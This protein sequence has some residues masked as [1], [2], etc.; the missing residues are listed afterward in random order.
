MNIRTFPDGKKRREAIEANLE[1]KLPHIGSYSLDEEQAATKHCENFI[2][3]TQVPLGIAGP[4]VIQ[5]IDREIYVPLA[6]TEGALI[7]SLQRGCK[8]IQLSGGAKVHSEYVGITRAPAFAI[9]GIQQGI[10]IIDWMQKHFEKLQVVTRK[11]SEHISLLNAEPYMLGT[12]LFVR[13][14]FDTQDAMGMNMATHATEEI[15]TYIEEQKKITCI[16]LS[17]NMCVDK[18]ANY[19]NFINGRGHKTWVEVH[20]PKS[21][22]KEVLKTTIPRLLLVAEKK[23]QQG[24]MLSGSIGAN[25]HIANTIAAIFLATGQDMGHVGECSMGV[26]S[27]EEKNNGLYVSVYLPDLVIGT[28]GGGTMLATQKETLRILGVSGGNNG[29]NAKKLATIIGGIVLAGELSLLASLAQGSLAKAHNA[30]GR[31]K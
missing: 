23:L 18:K 16:S 9:D 20:I 30:L 29:K 27:L 24:S 2:G 12:T 13:F 21:V 3:I 22:V 5:G 15:V 10:E 19:L 28:V 11:T 25:A 6:T 1:I 26:T 17:G 7:A 4:L 31:E 14:S 8:A